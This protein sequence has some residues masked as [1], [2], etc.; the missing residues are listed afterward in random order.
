MTKPD[1]LTLSLGAGVQSGT[2]AEMVAEGVLQRPDIAIFADTGDEPDY[3]YQYV[4][5]LRGRLAGVG[6]P[7]EVVRMG[8]IVSGYYGGGRF[9]AIPLYMQHDDGSIG[10]GRRQCTSEYKVAPIEATIKREMLRRG[11]ARQD[12]LDRIYV[13]GTVTTWLG[14]SLD[15]V[16]RMKPSPHAWQRLAWPLIDRRMSRHSCKVWLQE[17]N[18]PVPRKSSCRIC[19][20]HGNNYWRAL[21]DES[22]DDWA[23]VVE[24]DGKLRDGSLRVTH[25][26]DARQYLHRDCIPLA[27]VDLR[28]REEISGQLRL[29]DDEETGCDSGYC[30][31]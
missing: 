25:T 20:F 12:S 31:V 3:V 13:T 1:L 7:L 17:R 30:F 11:K 5:Y 29:F 2:L 14:L 24:F 4:D 26:T 27:D 9:A 6:V 16:Q 28:T 18:L 8:D 19:P 22:P 21:R 23:H 10:R 15:E